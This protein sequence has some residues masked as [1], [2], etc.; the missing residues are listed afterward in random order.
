MLQEHIQHSGPHLSYRVPNDL[1]KPGTNFYFRVDYKDLWFWSAW[2]WSGDKV[3][4][5]EKPVIHPPVQETSDKPLVHGR[6]YPGA[7]VKLVQAGYGGVVHGSGVV[8]VY[9]EWHIQVTEKLPVGEF[10]M[11]ANQTSNN[12]VSDWAETVTFI[13]RP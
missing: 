4:T 3:M 6:G 1:I 13:V 5:I 9:G 11:T 12:A 2:A 8:N 7:T 10:R